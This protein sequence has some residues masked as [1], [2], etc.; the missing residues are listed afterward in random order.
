MRKKFSKKGPSALGNVESRNNSAKNNLSLI[1]GV[2]SIL[3]SFIF[4]YIVAITGVL[5][6]IFAYVEKGKVQ[7]KANIWAFVLNVVGLFLAIVFLTISLVAILLYG[8]DLNLFEA[9]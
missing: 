4:P 6:L 8:S 9:A 5:G 1:L 7:R 3:I 2:F